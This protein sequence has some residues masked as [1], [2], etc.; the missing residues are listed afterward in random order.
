MAFELYLHSCGYTLSIHLPGNAK[1]VSGALF[2]VTHGT[3]EK[4]PDIR[5]ANSTSGKRVVEFFTQH[6]PQFLNEQFL[7]FGISIEKPMESTGSS[8]F[9]KL[10][11][12]QNRGSHF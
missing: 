10:F 7:F 1:I 3:I 6:E 11:V 8:A 5:A 2:H 9:L 12:Q 4:I